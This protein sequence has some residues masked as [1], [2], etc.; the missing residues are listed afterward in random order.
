MQEQPA[1]WIEFCYFQS[2]DVSRCFRAKKTSSSVIA[3]D[4]FEGTRD[5]GSIISLEQIPFLGPI[6]RRIDQEGAAFFESGRTLISFLSRM[7]RSLKQ[8]EMTELHHF[9][10]AAFAGK[11]L[12]L[13]EF[14]PVSERDG[15]CRVQFRPAD[16][17][18]NRQCAIDE[19]KA[20]LG[21]FRQIEELSLHVHRFEDWRTT[22][23]LTAIVRFELIGTRNGED[24]SAIDRAHFRMA[25]PASPADLTQSEQSHVH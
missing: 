2:A 9:Y 19:W 15:I 20:Y 5:M 17:V 6:C 12:G 11:R 10:D 23:K 25:W 21:G 24:V 18:V 13:N 14:S 1:R 22:D 16:L 3:S 8:G 4:H 7:G